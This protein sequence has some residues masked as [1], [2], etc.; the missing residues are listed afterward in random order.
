MGSRVLNQNPLEGFK[1][2]PT[3]RVHCGSSLSPRVLN[4]VDK[5]VLY[6]D[7]QG[8]A[9]VLRDRLR[10]VRSADPARATEGLRRVALILTASHPRHR[11][12][13]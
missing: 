13:R 3:R 6:A 9:L 8:F 5:H 1:P 2:E 7:A 4:P 12:D 10:G 11:S